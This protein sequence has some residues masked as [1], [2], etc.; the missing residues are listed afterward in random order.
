MMILMSLKNVLA[1]SNQI[2]CVVS[3]FDIENSFDFGQAKFQ[4]SMIMLMG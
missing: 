2:Q 4:Q 1:K 3:T